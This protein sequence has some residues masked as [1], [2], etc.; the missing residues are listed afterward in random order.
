MANTLVDKVFLWSS[1]EGFKGLNTVRIEASLKYDEKNNTFGYWIGFC[2][3]SDLLHTA[4]VHGHFAVFLLGIY[5]WIKADTL[6]STCKILIVVIEL[7]SECLTFLPR[8]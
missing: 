4:M 1:L 6:G 3:N 7:F 5:T 2:S 8:N